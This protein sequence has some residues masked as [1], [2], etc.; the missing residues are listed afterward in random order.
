[1]GKGNNTP[2]SVI[3]KCLHVLQVGDYRS[4]FVDHRTRKLT[5][6]KAIQIFVESQLSRRTS[7]EEIAE[8]L[9]LTPELQDERLTSISASQLSRTLK[10]IPTEVLQAIFF[11]NIARIRELTKHKQGI[12]GIGK[13]RIMDSTMLAL[14]SIAGRWANR[15]RSKSIRSWW[16][17]TRKR[18][19]PTRSW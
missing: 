4:L 16:W 17:R 7:Y 14:P 19:I 9:R 11:Q 10:Q 5:V 1:M 12:P 13:L 8:H 18:Y 2:K 3:C 15:M 6:G